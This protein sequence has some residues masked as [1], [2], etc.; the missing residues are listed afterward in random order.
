M[1]PN[2]TQDATLSD[3]I[4]NNGG[5]GIDLASEANNNQAPPTLTSA[6]YSSGATTIAGILS[7][8]QADTTYTL[9]FFANQTS[10]PP[11]AGQGQTLL[12]T[13]TVTTDGSGDATFTFSFTTQATTGQLVNAPAT[14][15][16]GNTSEVAQNV[17]VAAGPSPAGAVATAR[18]AL[19][20]AALASPATTGPASTNVALGPLTDAAFNNLAGTLTRPNRGAGS[21]GTN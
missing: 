20:G 21:A 9:Q 8:Q 15:P 16:N 17:T 11:G 19:P 4:Y 13:A 7:G 2:G 12:G 10:A 1:D 14:D 18:V 5:L 3:V 6:T